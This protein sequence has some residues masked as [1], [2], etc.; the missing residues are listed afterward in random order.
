[1]RNERFFPTTM[2]R[3]SYQYSYG[4]HYR[5]GA[6]LKYMWEYP[7]D[8]SS[9]DPVFGKYRAVFSGDNQF[10]FI[11]LEPF[12]DALATDKIYAQRFLD[13]IDTHNTNA[14]ILV[15]AHWPRKIYIKGEPDKGCLDFGELWLWTSG[16]VQ[17]DGVTYEIHP[18]ESKQH[19][20]QLVTYLRAQNPNRKILLFPA[21]HAFYEFDQMAKSGCIDGF[22]GVYDLL[23]DSIHPN[24]I[25][26][27]IVSCTLY[28]SVTGKS[29]VGLPYDNFFAKSPEHDALALAIQDFA[30]KV[31]QQNSDRTGFP[32]ENTPNPVK[33]AAIYGTENKT[34]F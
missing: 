2:N 23:R 10:D 7:D 14:T 34:G 22:N 29:P 6:G 20:D 19:F 32:S 4:F 5:G 33:T 26:Q 1:M 12:A 15:Y 27:Y 17:H 25:G 31:Q 24:P 18:E 13:L 3:M 21:A 9:D 30:L 11:L 28:A 16:P 8:T